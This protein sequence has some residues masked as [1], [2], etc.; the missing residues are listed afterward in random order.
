MPL[1]SAQ[2]LTLSVGLGASGAT[3]SWR[4]SRCRRARY[5]WWSKSGRSWLA[6]SWS[7]PRCC[8]TTASASTL[9]T[10]TPSGTSAVLLQWKPKRTTKS[11]LRTF[12]FSQE[13]CK[14]PLD[15]I[16]TKLVI[17]SVTRWRRPRRFVAP[18]RSTLNIQLTA[19]CTAIENMHTRTKFRVILI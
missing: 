17:N 18:V 10:R 15:G 9:R 13:G 8:R 7:P 11:V 19:G 14:L 4:S 6:A 1:D 2:L 3:C 16:E 5:K 12:F